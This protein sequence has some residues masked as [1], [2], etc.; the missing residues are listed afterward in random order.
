MLP[1]AITALDVIPGVF[2][3]THAAIGLTAILSLAKFETQLTWPK[4]I[5]WIVFI[6]VVP[7]V[8]AI[9]WFTAGRPRFR[10]ASGVDAAEDSAPHVGG[11]Q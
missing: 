3:L 6:A 11:T 1:P 2:A 4:M 7:L 5:A 8:G 10:S 9:V